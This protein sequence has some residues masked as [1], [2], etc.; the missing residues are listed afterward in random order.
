[1]E[2]VVVSCLARVE[3]PAAF[4]RKRRTGELSETDAATLSAS[5]EIDYAGTADQ[6]ARFLVIGVPPPLLEDAARL[7][8]VHGLRAYDALQLASARA[9]RSADPSCDTFA[10]ADTALRTAAAAEGFALLPGAVVPAGRS[11]RR[12]SRSGGGPA[13]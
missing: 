6:P 4:W 9:A 7:V 12:R 3:V 2:V 8:A 11:P 10:C 5:F 13:R 1:M